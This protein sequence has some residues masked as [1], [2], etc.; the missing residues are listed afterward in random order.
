MP[1]SKTGGMLVI[2]VQMRRGELDAPQGNNG[3]FFAASARLAG[4][5]LPCDIIVPAG[6]FAAPWQGWRIPVGP[7]DAPQSVEALITA[8]V[9]ADV[10]LTCQGHFLP[11]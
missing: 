5:K 3:L 4:A 11:Q 6:S 1:P 10:S 7:S 8:M 9:P 2:T